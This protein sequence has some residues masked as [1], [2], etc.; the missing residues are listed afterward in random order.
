MRSIAT[1]DCETDP[2]DGEIIPKP[3][4][5]GYFDGECYE[6]FKK[7][8]EL[9]EFIYTLP[10]Q[11]VYAHNGGKF[12]WHFLLEFIPP[13]ERV[14]IINGRLAKF[15]IGEVEF[16]DSWNILPVPMSKMQKDEFDYSKMHKSKRALHMN[17]I[18]RYLQNDCRYLYQFVN[19]FISDYGMSLTLAGAAMKTWENMRGAK[20]PHDR[21]GVL[22]ANFKHFYYGGRCQVFQD[23]LI[24]HAVDL[25]DIN[26]AYPFAMLSHHPINEMYGEIS[27]SKL[28]KTSPK[29][30]GGLFITCDAVSKGAFPFRAED[31]SLSFPDD[32]EVRT[33]HVTGWEYFAALETDTVDIKKIVRVFYFPVKTT[34]TDYVMH[35]YESRKEAQ[36]DDDKAG[37]LI[38]KLFMNSLYGKFGANPENYHEHIIAEP[39]A[40]DIDGIVRGAPMDV[41]LRGEW[42]FGGMLGTRYLAQKPLE[43]EAHRYYNVCTAASITGYV[44]AMLWK[45]ICQCE[46]VVYCDTDSIFC[47]DGS[48]LKLGKELGEWKLEA[49]CVGGAV[50]GKKLYTFERKDGTHKMASK[51]VKLTVD[52]LREI[53]QGREVVYHP[54]AP[55]F[56]VH[57]PPKHV[58]RIIRKR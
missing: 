42:S 30:Y 24:N 56:S 46:G 58:K 9:I 32:K 39:E 51:G 54:L 57:S 12:D 3:F 28:H 45:A 26:S 7:T 14:M 8:K 29:N 1:I 16:R 20:A 4:L 55:S 27:E 41:G 31:G 10:K 44:R 52:E 34:F 15:K 35:F 22:Y 19:R 25:Y 47:R 36:A 43:D 23:G 49:E 38:S 48:A 40:I 50:G 53:A 11:I 17:E 6:E 18:R 37:D 5:W 21:D 13:W 2:F 33:Y